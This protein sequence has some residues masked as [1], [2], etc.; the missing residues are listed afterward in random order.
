MSA[1]PQSDSDFLT[2]GPALQQ[3]RQL[4]AEAEARLQKIADSIPGCIYAFCLELDTGQSYFTY[5]S[6]GCE[7]LLGYPESLLTGP[8]TNWWDLLLQ[9]K[10]EREHIAELI[11]VSARQLSL[12]ETSFRFRH[13]L[14]GER[15][16][17]ARSIPERHVDRILWSGVFVNATDLKHQIEATRLRESLLQT[18]NQQLEQ[19]VQ[20][21]TREL[22]T[23]K[24][25]AEAAHQAK[26][27]FLANM[28]HEIRTPIHAILG[29]VQLIQEQFDYPLLQDYMTAIA[30]SGQNLLRLLND[31]LDLSKLEVGK[32]Q[33]QLAPVNLRAVAREIGSLFA[34]KASEKQ[35]GFYIDITPDL[36]DLLYLDETRIRQ[37]FFNLMGNAVKFTAEGQIQ[38]QIDARPSQSAPDC[39]DL[40]L[41]FQDT[42][43]GIPES[44]QALIFNAFMQQ[45]GQTAKQY[46]GTG[47]GLSIVQRLVQMMQGQITLTSQPQQG[48]CFT[49]FL[50][51]VQRVADNLSETPSTVTW[52]MQH[53]LIIA[54]P[55][56]QELLAPLYAGEGISM[57]ALTS[58]ELLPEGLQPHWILLQLPLQGENPYMSLSALRQDFPETPLS[59]LSA[60]PFDTALARQFQIKSWLTPPFDQHALNIAWVAEAAVQSPDALLPSEPVSEKLEFQNLVSRW[61]AVR[62][63]HSFDMITAFVQELAETA[64]QTQQ[65]KLLQ[66]SELLGAAAGR[67]DVVLIEQLLSGFPDL[68]ETL[69]DQI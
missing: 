18:L 8:D 41:S 12:F 43:I 13:P 57:L 50:P 47:L 66:F 22:Q 10:E 9:N 37:I 44:S 5:L 63:S 68:L 34:L 23:A 51:A 30:I 58:L 15:W 26:S 48:A 38:V 1:V 54:E 16:V 39:V 64:Q 24:E 32:M 35:V 49:L 60:S 52:P 36:P 46:G 69:R 33:L 28:S 14:H 56:I 11:Q 6:K 20:L 65:R 27:E 62:Q 3:A 29:Y 67:F 17:F 45:E 2:G 42:G 25:A 55:H 21:R 40:S 4:A 59:V 31:L 7:D 19:R 61:E 53:T